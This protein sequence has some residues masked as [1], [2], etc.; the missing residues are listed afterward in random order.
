[1]KLF[2]KLVI[3]LVL[4]ASAPVMGQL[5]DFSKVPNLY[6]NDSLSIV[7]LVQHGIPI[8]KK[9]SDLLVSGRLY[10]CTKDE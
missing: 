9:E 5:P 10:D 1:M 6:E 3:G 8:T 2:D 4:T 7:Y